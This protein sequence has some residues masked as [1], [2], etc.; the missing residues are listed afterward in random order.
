MN[1]EER[2]G[3][4]RHIPATEHRAAAPR[5]RRGA[6]SSPTRSA[7][8]LRPLRDGAARLRA[9]GGDQEPQ[10]AARAGP[11]RGPARRPGREPGRGRRLLLEHLR[12]RLAARAA[13]AAPRGGAWAT[14][15][16]LRPA[17]ARLW[18]AAAGLRRSPARLRAPAGRPLGR[19]AGGTAAAGGGFL[20]TA[21]PMAAGAAGGMLLGS[22]LSNAFAG[23]HS[24]LGSMAGLGGAGAAGGTTIE[25]NYF[26]NQGGSEDFGA[27]LGGDDAGFQ[28]PRSTAT[29][30]RR[31]RRLGLIGPPRRTRRP[32]PRRRGGGLFSCR[33][34]IPA[35]SD[36][37]HAG[38]DRHPLVEV[39]TSSF[40]IRMQPDE[41]D[42]PIVWGSL[43]PWMR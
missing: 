9:G 29:W 4:Q 28:T 18:P 13:A 43:V 6:L 25:N 24:S 2:T 7:P 36:H 31:Q 1:S 38:A 34:T 35:A 19:P 32:P 16:R 14:R 41:T 8:P 11:G 23:G 42:W 37:H 17:T 10:P 15:G 22:A 5:C 26:G 40:I 20:A 30:R 21:L 12:R 27:P 33:E 3:H 39:V